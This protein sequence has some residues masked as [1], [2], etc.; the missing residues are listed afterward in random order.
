MVLST[1]Q[2]GAQCWEVTATSTEGEV[3]GAVRFRSKRGAECY[4]RHLKRYPEDTVAGC[5]EAKTVELVDVETIDLSV[6]EHILQDALDAMGL[7]QARVQV[8]EGRFKDDLT[9]CVCAMVTLPNTPVI[10]LGQEQRAAIII[11]ATCDTD[12]FYTPDALAWLQEMCFEVTRA[13]R[14]Y[15]LK[16][17]WIELVEA[18]DEADRC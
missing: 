3:L 1:H 10:L 9:P 14:R 18:G 2:N 15:G 4:A 8:N 5:E 11:Y 17:H 12:V 16:A 7:P 6:A 13:A